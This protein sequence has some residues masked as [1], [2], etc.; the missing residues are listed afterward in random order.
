MF[1]IDL[2]DTKYSSVASALNVD[3]CL[4]IL[5]VPDGDYY[6]L[7]AL[8]PIQNEKVRRV[9]IAR[10]SEENEAI[11][12]YRDLMQ[13]IEEQHGIWSPLDVLNPLK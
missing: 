3:M 2:D 6:T 4:Q 11:T 10:F 13:K 7:A 9:N 8:V 5:I 1:I 12:V